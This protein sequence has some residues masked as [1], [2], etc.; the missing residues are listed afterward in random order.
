VSGGTESGID[1]TY[2]DATGKLEFSVSGGGG[3]ATDLEGLSD[4][5][6]PSPVR[7]ELNELDGTS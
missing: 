6:L 3:G 1:V 5:D 2:N 7:R 4:V